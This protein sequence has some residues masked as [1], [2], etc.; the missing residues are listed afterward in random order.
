MDIFDD[1]IRC[2]K[3]EAA[4]SGNVFVRRKDLAEF[5]DAAQ[6]SRPVLQPEPS[7]QQNCSVPAA[8][9][10]EIP[11]KTTE[12]P[13][14]I[15]VRCDVSGMDFARLR[16]CAMKCTACN[17]CQTRTNVVFGSGSEQADLMFIG[18]APGADEDAQGLPFVGK[19]GELLT[20]MIKAMKYDR[21]EVY[22]AN[23]LK[24]RPPENRNPEEQEAE[25]CIS[26]LKR[27]IELVK[28]EVIVLLGAVSMRFLL[29]KTGIS[30]LRGTWQEYNGIPVMP[31]YHPAFLLRNPGAKADVWKD[32]QAVMS[33]LG[34]L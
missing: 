29:G 7:L 1:I 22:I 10:V 16:E 8:S 24:C 32:L 33:R 21:S 6:T 13:V 9:P 15:T 2:M 11:V 5:M 3:E 31:T 20:K 28:P 23:I 14:Q 26:I 19:A 12:S 30:K 34:K 25:A 27:Q 18:E 4:S 17:L